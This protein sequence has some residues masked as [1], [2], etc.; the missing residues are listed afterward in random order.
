MINNTHR[1]GNFTSSNIYKLLEKDRA[2]KNFGAGAL[3]YIEERNMERIIGRSIAMETEAKPLQWGKMCESLVFQELSTA[4]T[5]C[6]DVTIVHPEHSYWSGSPDGYTDDT[7]MDI[8]C[9]FT[10]KSWFTLTQGENIYSMIDGFSIKGAAFGSHKSG[11]QYYWQLISNA[12]LT[13]KKMG[14]LIV[15]VPR[16]NQLQ[17]IRNEAEF[18]GI[19]WIKYASDDELPYVSDTFKNLVK[20]RFEIPQKDIDLLTTAVIEAGKML[21]P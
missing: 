10:L 20:I 7:V 11:K 18:Q 19:N 21:I 2:G 1:I 6:S 13:G 9:P 17:D 16:L 3:T 5:L 12:I 8:K 14:E 4:Y 15:F